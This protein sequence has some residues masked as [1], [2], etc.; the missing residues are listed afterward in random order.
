MSRGERTL[1]DLYAVGGAPSARERDLRR[2]KLSRDAVPLSSEM[3]M[4]GGLIDLER[5]P[6]EGRAAWFARL[7]AYDVV[8][9]SG[10]SKRP[11]RP[12]DHALLLAAAESGEVDFS[13]RETAVILHHVQMR[14]SRPEAA[15][16]CGMAVSTLLTHYDKA[17]RKARR[18][19]ANRR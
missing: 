19:G 6:W 1:T 11:P 12:T 4:S 18:W 16:R 15:K 5:Q 17:R 8:N 9:D 7:R 3:G 13:A 14:R 10:P 2:Y